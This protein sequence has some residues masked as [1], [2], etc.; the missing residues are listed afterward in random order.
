MRRPNVKIIG[1]EE[2]EDSQ[3]KWP[4]SIFNKI[5]KENFPNINRGP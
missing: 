1:R 5:I 2:R 4:V 3:I